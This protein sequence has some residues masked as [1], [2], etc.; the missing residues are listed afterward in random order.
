MSK[1]RVK[2]GFQS[3]NGKIY[4]KGETFEV[5]SKK[6]LANPD[7]ARLCEKVEEEDEETV[8][9]EVGKK[10]GKGKGKDKTAAEESAVKIPAEEAA[11]DDAAAKDE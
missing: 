8:A 11:K 3:I 7:R 10:R 1:Y 5:D 4:G 2:A 9:E 6:F